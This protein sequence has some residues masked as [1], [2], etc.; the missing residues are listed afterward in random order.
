MQLVNKKETLQVNAE[1]A[2]LVTAA[3][4]LA[5]AESR[6]SFTRSLVLAH[7]AEFFGQHHHTIE[8]MKMATCAL[9]DML[10]QFK[11]VER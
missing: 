10:D 6:I 8:H 5:D 3:I 2:E 9:C 1:A 7:D 11:G 4:G